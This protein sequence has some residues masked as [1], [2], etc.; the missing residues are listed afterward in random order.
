MCNH[1]FSNF[2]QLKISRKNLQVGRIS[3]CK[4]RGLS[5]WYNNLI[6]RWRKRPLDPAN[7]DKL[8]ENRENPNH[9]IK[10]HNK[11]QNAESCNYYTLNRC[12]HHWWR[13]PTSVTT[14]PLAH[15]TPFSRF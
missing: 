9:T 6:L 14:W 7:S 13:M 5:A 4:V 15:R 11:R 10:Y 8:K 3:W 2:L 1:M 12:D